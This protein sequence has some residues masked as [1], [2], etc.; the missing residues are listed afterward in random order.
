MQGVKIKRYLERTS[1]P[2][3]LVFHYDQD[4]QMRL[5]HK[6]MYETEKLSA[7][8]DLMMNSILYEYLFLL[9]RRF[10]GKTAAFPEK[11][12][13]YMEEALRFIESSYCDPITVQNIADH[14]MLNR[15][16]LHRIFKSVTGMSLQDYLT[17]YRIRQ[18]CI[19]LQTTDLSVRVIAH[20]VSFSDP[21]YFS[22]LFRQ[23]KGISPREYRALNRQ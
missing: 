6:K 9:A 21:L 12:N 19:L 23:K 17:D 11:K 18:A 15:S 16:C 3:D 8:R 2:E 4:D 14:L 20:S 7:N 1:L 10:P 22:R 5:C 13:S